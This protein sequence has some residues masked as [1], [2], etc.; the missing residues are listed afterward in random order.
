M[1]SGSKSATGAKG[2]AVKTTTETKDNMAKKRKPSQSRQNR[3]VKDS[4]TEALHI[5]QAPRPLRRPGVSS[6]KRLKTSA[7][8]LSPRQTKILE[9][10]DLDKVYGMNSIEGDFPEVN[11]RTL[12]RDLDKLQQLGLIKKTG[13]TKASLYQKL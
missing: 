7:E 4:P 11:V 13:S 12:R 1:S 10:L 3:A 8:N 9:I 2:R 6:K 5:S